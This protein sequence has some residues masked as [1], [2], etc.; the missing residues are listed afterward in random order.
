MKHNILYTNTKDEGF[1]TMRIIDPAAFFDN[2]PH[3]NDNK[4]QYTDAEKEALREEIL[5][6]TSTL[7]PHCGTYPDYDTD[8]NGGGVWSCHCGMTRG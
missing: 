8:H 1:I 5:N 4:Y 3:C 2:I 6:G 7:C